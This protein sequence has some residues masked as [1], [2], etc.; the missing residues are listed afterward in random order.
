M[1]RSYSAFEI[2]SSPT[3]ATSFAPTLF[4]SLPQPAATKTPARARTTSAIR[5]GFFIKRAP[6]AAISLRCLARF[7]YS[8]DQLQRLRKLGVLNRNFI[9]GGAVDGRVD[10]V[11][12]RPQLFGAEDDR[13]DRGRAAP[14]D[15][16]VGA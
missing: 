8:I 1:R 13:P 9:S 3:T 5:C 6:F 12:Q 14:E 16:V 11:A 10:P 2:V 4:L 7:E 15:Q